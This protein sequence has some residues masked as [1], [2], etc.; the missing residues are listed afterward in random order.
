M[1]FPFKYLIIKE[2]SVFKIKLSEIQ[3]ILVYLKPKMKDR[4]FLSR[5][6]IASILYTFAST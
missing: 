5:L 2:L 6:T 1:L 4:C 3:I